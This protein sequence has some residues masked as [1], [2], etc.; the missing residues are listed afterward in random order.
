[1]C[2]ARAW[3]GVPHHPRRCAGFATGAWRAPIFDLTSVSPT[4]AE[5]AQPSFASLYRNQCGTFRIPRR[6]TWVWCCPSVFL[7][8]RRTDISCA[9]RHLERI[10][11]LALQTSAIF[12]IPAAIS[13]SSADF[14]HGANSPADLGFSV[15]EPTPPP[16]DI[17]TASL[18]KTDLWAD[19]PA[20]GH[21]SVPGEDVRAIWRKRA[22]SFGSLCIP[23]P[24]R[25]MPKH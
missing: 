3:S 23:K 11:I 14:R 13:C 8:L 16:D 7:N 22:L 12:C 10:P 25:R 9:L 21:K 6:R 20:D 2:S 24:D 17:E 1:M 18:A 4:S 5:T 15:P 19:F